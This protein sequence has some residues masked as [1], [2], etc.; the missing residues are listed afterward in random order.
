MRPKSYSHCHRCLQRRAV[1]RGFLSSLDRQTYGIGNIEVV[2]VDDGSTDDSGDIVERWSRTTAATVRVI[3]Q[4]NAGQGAARNAGIKVATG[5]WVTF[6]DPDDVLAETY[7]QEIA[8][9]LDAQDQVPDLVAGRLLT[10][11]EDH[12]QHVDHHPLRGN[13]KGKNQLV[14]LSRFPSRVHLSGASSFLQLDRLREAAVEFDSRIRPTFEDGHFIGVYLL[15]SAAPLVGFVRT[16]E[17]YYRKRVDNS[18]S[19]QTG[20]SRDEKYTNVLRHGFLDLLQRA[21]GSYGKA[22]L[23][24]QNTVLYDLFWYFKTDTRLGAPTGAIADA[25]LAEFHVL[26]RDILAL[27]DAETILG[28]GIHR[29]D[30]WLRLALVAGYKNPQ[31]RPDYVVLDSLDDRQRVVRARYYFGG[32]RPDEA[33][34]WRGRAVMPGH[35]KVRAVKLLGRTLMSERVVWLPADGTLSVALDGRPIPLSTRGAVDLP[36]TLTPDQLWRSLGGRRPGDESIRPKGRRARV[37]HVLE[38]PARGA[39]AAGVRAQEWVDSDQWTALMAKRLAATAWARRRYGGAWVLVDRQE[40][41]KDNGEHLY[42]YLKEKQPA[43]NAWF[44]LER[45]SEDWGRL[46]R[47]GFKLVPY[48]SLQWRAL[49]LNARHVLSS[50]VNAYVTNPLPPK[51]YGAPGWKFTFLQHGVTKDDLSR[52]LNPKR[53]HLVSTVTESETNSFIGDGTSYFFTGREVQRTGFPRHDSLLRRAAELTPGQVDQI[54]IM[55]TWRRSLTDLIPDDMSAEERAEVFRSSTYGQHWLALLRSPELE[56]MARR[57]GL[58]ITLLPHP[59]PGMAEYLKSAGLPSHVDVL[60][61]ESL[62]VQDVLACSKMLV[63]DYTSVAFDMAMLGR[64]VA[65]YQFDRQE[66][67]SSGHLFRRGYFDYDRDGFGPVAQ[68][69][70]E[71]IPALEKLAADDFVPSEAVAHRIEHA[72]GERDGNACHRVFKAV[73][74]LD[75]PIR[76]RTLDGRV[77]A[78]LPTGSPATEAQSVRDLAENIDFEGEPED[79]MTAVAGMPEMTGEDG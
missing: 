45:D 11:A 32:D 76:P 33:L 40:Q 49:L 7:F 62:D 39:A 4:E 78:V 72:L 47:E 46:A 58:K 44:V 17:Y 3:H 13:F 41:A 38:A 61:W 25:V 79:E 53:I 9:F 12:S 48:G 26:C 36:Y 74:R 14:D 27:I 8:T 64:P 31:L 56:E 54:L 34:Y 69:Y 73:S 70:E 71:L 75:R 23:W 6:P 60:S 52:W 30:H 77:S 5:Q 28:F 19:V 68:S 22:P 20:W 35:Q 59:H 57:T 67:F 2:L 65:Y 37:R 66:F 63:T 21:E 55:P 51:L 16:A 15:S 24:V 10:F 42:R 18:S 50:H 29:T 43:V 1:S